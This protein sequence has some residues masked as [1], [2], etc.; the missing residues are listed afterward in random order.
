MLFRIEDTQNDKGYHRAYTISA[1]KLPKMKLCNLEYYLATKI[2]EAVN[3]STNRNLLNY[4]KS[5]GICLLKYNN[6]VDNELHICMN[7]G[8]N[9]VSFYDIKNKKCICIPFS[10]EYGLQIGNAGNDSRDIILQNFIV[11]VSDNQILDCYLKK[12]TGIGRK[13]VASP[14]KDN[15]VILMQLPSNTHDMVVSEYIS[16]VYLLYGLFMKYGMNEAVYR[17]LIYRINNLEDFRFEFCDE[18]EKISILEIISYLYY[19]GVFDI[20]MCE[21]V[22]ND[23]K[24][25]FRVPIYYDS[26]LQLHGIQTDNFDDSYMLSDY[27]DN[28][29]SSWIWDIYDRYR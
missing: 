28:I 29:I 27:N 21:R 26:I 23:I 6:Y 4:S 15:E 25:S 17:N 13:K 18:T 11:D 19:Y 2:R 10:I 22:Y 3:N 1:D 5:L 16:S 9:S 14:E 7:N 20:G 12:T 24:K 8:L